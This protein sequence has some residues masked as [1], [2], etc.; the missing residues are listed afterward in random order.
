MQRGSQS[1][2]CRWQSDTVPRLSTNLKHQ[3]CCCRRLPKNPNFEYT[4]NQAPPLPSVTPSTPFMYQLSAC[5]APNTQ[6]KSAESH[7]KLTFSHF[8]A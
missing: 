8:S 1:K 6:R 5:F 3:Q 4:E 7:N 2:Y